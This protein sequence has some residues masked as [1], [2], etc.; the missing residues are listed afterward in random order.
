MICKVNKT[1]TI[2]GL[3]LGLGILFPLEA[4]AEANE[5]LPIVEK[6]PSA[7]GLNDPSY[8]LTN[9]PDYDRYM[10]WGYDSMDKE[11]YY[12]ASTYFQ[13]ALNEFPSNKYAEVAYQNA[14]KMLDEQNIQ[15]TNQNKDYDR[16]MEAG[17]RA[18]DTGSYYLAL[19]HFHRALKERPN[20]DYALEAIENIYTYLDLN[21]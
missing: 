14:L 21:K 19:I 10:R 7:R 8:R 16:Y 18:T 15:E 9:Q 3:L 17:Y 20:D 2:L 11:N 13:K 5:V 1:T 12:I 4:K 6:V